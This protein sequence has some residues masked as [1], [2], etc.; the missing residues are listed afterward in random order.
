MSIAWAG[1]RQQ[2]VDLCLELSRRGYFSGTGGNLALRIDP[3]HFAVTPSA[4][5]YH[6]MTV[7]NV[8]ILRLANLL[9][10]AG[11]RPPSVESGLHARVLRQRRDVSCSI[12]T[13]QPIA[14]AWALTGR[15]LKIEDPALQADLGDCVPVVGYAPSGTGWLSA[16]FGRK[17]RAGRNAYLL[18][19]HGVVCCGDN[20]DDA[21]RK[22]TLLEH[23]VRRRLRER[24]IER[25]ALD[26]R[27]QPALQRVLANLER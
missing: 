5:D 16:K 13:H 9:Q 23:L 26:A 27:L 1:I 20:A 7:E 8:S 6:V 10:V 15:S 24:I 11:D 4:T 25:G 2:V 12:H 14:S 3:D 18:F 22:L 21:L 17:L 19:N